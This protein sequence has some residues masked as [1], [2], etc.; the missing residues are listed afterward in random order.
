MTAGRPAFPVLR[1]MAL[2]WLAIYVPCY[3]WA[4]GPANF[5]FLCNLAVFLV[6]AGLWRGDAMLLSSQA[7]GLLAVSL[8]WT[9]DFSSRLATGA[10]WIGGTEYM[11]DSKWPAFARALSLYHVAAPLVLL[12]GLRRLGYDAR[13]YPLQSALAVAG[14]LLG[15]LFGPDANI[16]GAF[17]DPMF[18]RVWGPPPI[19]LAVVAGALV[20]GV[21]P[22]THLVLRRAFR[23]AVSSG[24]A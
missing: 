22:L 20:L 18:R 5:L 15:R 10:H 13:G 6:A 12:H 17:A 9:A 3:A 11:W 2:A 1:W 7:V 24:E 14:V 21:Y 23:P 8:V 4:Y 19:H 16:N